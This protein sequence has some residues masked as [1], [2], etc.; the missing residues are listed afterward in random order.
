MIKMAARMATIGILV[1][2]AL[3]VALP[4]AAIYYLLLRFGA[5]KWIEAKV[6]SVGQNIQFVAFWAHLGVA[7]LLVEHLP[8]NGLDWALLIC[9]AAG[10]KEY[11]FDA[12]YEHDPPQTFMDN[13]QDFIGWATGAIIGYVF[14]P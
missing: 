10:L 12:K 1:L 3:V 14:R 9:L 4:V 5:I 8:D 6:A 2:V 11:W 13:T 7:A